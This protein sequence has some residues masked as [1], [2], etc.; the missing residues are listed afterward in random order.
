MVT[1]ILGGGPTQDIIDINFPLPGLKLP[2]ESILQFL[3]EVMDRKPRHKKR[4]EVCWRSWKIESLM[5]VV[6][7]S[8]VATVDIPF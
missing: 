5:V 4:I 7:S 3:L 8:T 1:G 2:E 6:S